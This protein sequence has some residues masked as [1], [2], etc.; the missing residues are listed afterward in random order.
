MTGGGARGLRRL[1]AWLDRLIRRETRR[2]RRLS[3]VLVASLAYL[4]AWLVLQ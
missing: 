4:S 3:W 2:D 1:P